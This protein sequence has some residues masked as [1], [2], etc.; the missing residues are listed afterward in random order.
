MDLGLNQSGLTFKVVILYRW[1]FGGVPSY[2]MLRTNC[3]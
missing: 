2:V 3:L 1:L